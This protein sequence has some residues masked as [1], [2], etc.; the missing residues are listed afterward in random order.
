MQMAVQAAPASCD[1]GLM[2]QSV[3]EGVGQVAE[4]GSPTMEDVQEAA[5]SG[6][7]AGHEDDPKGC[8]CGH[9]PDLNGGMA[10][11]AWLTFRGL[12]AGLSDDGGDPEGPSEPTHR[13][14]K[15]VKECVE[16]L[17]EAHKERLEISPGIYLDRKEARGYL[18]AR[19]VGLGLLPSAQLAHDV[20][21]QLAT[22]LAQAEKDARKAAAAAR[23]KAGRAGA[24]P[25]PGGPREKA[26][27]A[28][29]DAVWTRPASL[30]SLPKDYV[31]PPR[32][33][34]RKRKRAQPTTPTTDE[35]DAQ[36]PV[37]DLQPEDRC[38][39][40]FGDI[41]VE[42]DTFEEAGAIATAELES[43]YVRDKAARAAERARWEQEQEEAQ[44]KQA[45]IDER[46]RAEDYRVAYNA[47]WK[48]CASKAER[49][50]YDQRN[51]YDGICYAHHSLMR[52]YERALR[53]ADIDPN[54]VVESESEAEVD[55]TV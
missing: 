29:A 31:A 32:P 11:L 22:Q 8:P 25:G 34:R 18:I 42:A 1:E 48:A 26:A 28:A 50:I 3:V 40:K 7:E 44:A 16:H 27:E 17:I 35:S 13:D 2:V 9:G 30:A 39:L 49:M 37:E 47:G 14:L 15:H 23:K 38:T 53:K 51:M 33:A 24:P 43:R 52:A 6:D 55:D 36:R 46:L 54:E 20:G 21:I 12:E 4:N 19:H 45:E 41:E 5:S 10:S